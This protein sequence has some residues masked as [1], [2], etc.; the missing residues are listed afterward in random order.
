MA[1]WSTYTDAQK[2]AWNSVNRIEA[3]EKV[4]VPVLRKALSQ[5]ALT[6]EGKQ[7]VPP[8][9]ETLLD[10]FTKD[11]SINFMRLGNFLRLGAT[12]ERFVREYYM[13][14]RGIKNR[15]QLRTVLGDHYPPYIFRSF[16]SSKQHEHR[17][18]VDLY[19][20]D[21]SIDL[22]QKPGFS[23]VQ[24]YFIHRAL[25]VHKNGQVDLEYLELIEGLLGKKERQR[26]HDLVLAVAPGDE[27]EDA[28]A[29]WFEPIDKNLLHYVDRAT[30]FILDLEK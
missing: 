22:T 7:V 17:T 10:V 6:E 30:R 5:R 25:Y 15:Q 16:Y 23:S 12:L 3:A 29:Y 18:I 11:H 21:L 20:S 24:E 1:D 9:C 4:L 28:H 8:D 2:S 27:I 14:R 19:R 13:E 26:I